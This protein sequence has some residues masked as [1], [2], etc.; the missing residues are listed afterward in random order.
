MNKKEIV[1][2]IKKR[3]KEQKISQKELAEKLGVTAAYISDIE[4]LRKIPSMDKLQEILNILGGD[5]SEF[6]NQDKKLEE[7]RKLFGQMKE[8]FIAIEKLL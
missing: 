6:G 5:I 7:L 3:R 4:T 1:I 8:I 2:Q